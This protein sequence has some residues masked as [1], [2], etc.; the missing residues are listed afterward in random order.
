[1]N[2]YKQY[3][4]DVLR[5]LQETELSVLKEFI[6]ICDK[7]EIRYFALFG[8]NIGAARH[9]GFIPWDDDI[10]IGML[11]KDYEKLLKIVPEECGDEYRMVGP[12]CEEKFYNLVPHFC[13][14]GTRFATN[15]DHGN[16]NMGIG[17]DIFV[18]DYLA[19][20]EKQ[21][22]KQVRMTSFWRG[23][24]MAHNVDFYK[25]SVFKKGNLLPR[26]AAGAVHRILRLIPGADDFI[27]KRYLEHARAFKK[28]TDYVT[29]FADSMNLQCAIAWE[30]L[31]PL[32]KLPFEDIEINVPGEYDKL[33]T[34][35]YGDYM[36]LPPEEK[37]RIITRICWI[38]VM[39]CAFVRRSKVGKNI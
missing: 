1:M 8:T 12:D 26:L 18:Y 3:S 31:L 34:R 20:D 19:D 38:S 16:Y 10:D 27:Y 13:K 15:Y 36:A 7:Y 4:P 24:Y 5:K 29:Q 2:R 11:R 25:N 37:D 6:R 33:L 21:R 14:N 39:D 22:K 28:K 23:L 17:F 9:Q 30:E 35:V 32:A